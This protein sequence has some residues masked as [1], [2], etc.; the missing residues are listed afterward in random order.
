M[1]NEN[2]S[3]FPFGD[4]MLSENIC[5]IIKDGGTEH[6]FS[7]KYVNHKE[8]GEYHCVGCDA[9][10]FSSETKF[11][12]G[13]GWPSF[14]D[15]LDT[16][17]ILKIKDNSFGMN[18]VEI[19]CS[20]CNAHLGHVFNDG[21]HPTGLRYCVNSL[22]LEFVGN[23]EIENDSNKINRVGAT[24]G[25]GCFWCIEA[26]FKQ[27][28]GIIEVFP[29]YAGGHLTHPSYE[30]VCTGSTGHAEVARIVYNPLIISFTE[31]LKAFWW[32]HD[33]TQL[34]RQG[35]DI[36]SQYRSVVFYHTLEQK[37]L[38][39]DA[40]KILE[41]EKV[42]VNP[43]VTEVTEINN[44]FKAENYHKD[45]FANHPENQYCQ[46]IVRPKVEK[47]EKIFKEKLKD[48]NELE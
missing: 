36:G 40:I 22:A 43:I 8:K 21:P 9:P 46:M 10:L 45:Y 48:L 3:L 39:E 42:W 14:F 28:N 24:F 38:V 11:D 15:E 12:S 20:N 34:N 32:I 2:P 37:N 16:L 33:P 13:S 25:A 1:K 5:H 18:R 26:C 27:L 6:A 23:N 17:S 29:G 30:A 19:K 41:V 44:F 4:K 35:D 7:G 31:L 47:F